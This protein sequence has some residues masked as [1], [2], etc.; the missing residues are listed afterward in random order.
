MRFIMLL[1]LVSLL[2][3]IACEGARSIQGQ[4]LAVLGASGSIVGMVAGLGECI[5]YSFRLFFGYL[6]D[7]SDKHW[8]YTL[9]GYTI[10]LVAIPLFALVTSW[11]MAAQLVLLER[12]GKAIRTP[13]RDAMISYATDQT[14]R[15]IGFGIHKAMDSIGAVVGPL[16]ISLVLLYAHGY[17]TA[18]ALLA[19]P[20]ALSLYALTRARNFSPEPKEFASPQLT[21][22]AKGFSRKFWLAIIALS[23]VGA[24]TVDFSLMGF[25]LQKSAAVSVTM[26]PLLFASAMIVNGLSALGVG[27][28]YDRFGIPSL[29]AAL[30]LGIFATPLVFLGNTPMAFIGSLVWG[31]NLATQQAVGRALIADLVPVSKRGAAYGIFYISYGL[32]WLMG[33]TSMG[34]LYDV[35]LEGMIAFSIIA[36]LITLPILAKLRPL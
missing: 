35:S 26:I 4:Y 10:N 30:S 22:S 15:G 12:L 19:V 7:T 5:G 14:G 36:Q 3:D 6:S 32:C 20:A 1:G 24:G 29:I 27:R 34:L 23:C 33:S 13:P 25:H 31:L 17:P 28:L 21:S 16:A 8:R 18:F 2:A 9:L 11:P